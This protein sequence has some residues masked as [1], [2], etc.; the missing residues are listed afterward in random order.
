[1]K[2]AIFDVQEAKGNALAAE[3]EAKKLLT[4][5]HTA[6]RAEVCHR[7]DPIPF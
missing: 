4:T 1:V 5:I 7:T 6:Q 2:A 3:L